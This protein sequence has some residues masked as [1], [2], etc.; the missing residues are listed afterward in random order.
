MLNVSM[1]SVIMLNV[2]APIFLLGMEA[3]VNQN[4]SLIFRIA[5]QQDLFNCLC[6]VS[7]F[8]N[9]AG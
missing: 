4:V 5:C 9:D 1:L 2:M 6:R 8:T 3:K 7:I